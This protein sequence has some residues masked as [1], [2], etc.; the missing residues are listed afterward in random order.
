M[1][2]EESEDVQELLEYEE[3]SAGGLMTTDY[4]AL[5]ASKS[6]AEALVA[7][8]TSV[9]EQDVAHPAYVYCVANELEDESVLLGLA[10]L[11]D[12]LGA[13]PT[14]A[15]QQLMDTDLITR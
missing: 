9:R 7:V 3:T 13:E 2:T 6:A 10:S 1:K 5:T 11:W 8:R 14:R 15:L 12:L 4:I